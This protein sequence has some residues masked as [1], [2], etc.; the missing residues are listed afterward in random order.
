[1]QCLKAVLL[2]IHQNISFYGHMSLNKNI[3]LL[4]KIFAV[5]KE[6]VILSEWNNQTP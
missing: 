5:L 4:P 1:M 3:I 2:Q 6:K